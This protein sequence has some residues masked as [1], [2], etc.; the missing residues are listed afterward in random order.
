LFAALTVELLRGEQQNL[1]TE[2]TVH[3]PPRS[4]VWVAT[5]TGLTPGQQVWRSTGLTNRE[6]ALAQAKRWEAE[7]RQQRLAQGLGS[8]SPPYVPG[9]VSKVAAREKLTQQE[10]AKRLGMS[11]A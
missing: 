3:M 9:R 11:E 5:F 7:A 1:I 6:E 10:V 8:K 4:N 2:A